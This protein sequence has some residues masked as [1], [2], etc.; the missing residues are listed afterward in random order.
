ML[1]VACCRYFS[2][3]DIE[4]C[5]CVYPWDAD[6]VY[7]H[8]QTAEGAAAGLQGVLQLSKRQSSGCPALPTP[9][10]ANGSGGSSSGVG[11]IAGN[12]ASRAAAVAS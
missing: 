4:D 9:A 10:H 5:W 7:H 6:D 1:L 11:S 3:L 8:T 12:G 2:A